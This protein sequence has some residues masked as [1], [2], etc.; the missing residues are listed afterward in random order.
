MAIDFSRPGGNPASLVGTTSSPLGNKQATVASSSSQP[1]GDSVQLSQD[2][3]LLQDVNS[4]LSKVPVVD[5]NKVQQ[6][7]QAIADGQYSIDSLQLADKM[8]RFETQF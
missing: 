2:A 7:R 1:T 8:M 3:R 5:E 4:S 6:L